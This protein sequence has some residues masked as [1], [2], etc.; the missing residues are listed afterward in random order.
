MSRHFLS[1]ITLIIVLPIVLFSSLS[2]KNVTISGVVNNPEGKP[3]KKVNV[4]IR[5]LKDEI[6]METT[7]NRKGQFKFEDVK[8][9]F[10]FLLA[11]DLG[12]GSKRIKI[13]P[14]KN[15]NSDMDLTF[16]LNGREQDVECYLFSNKPPTNT[17]PILGIKKIKAKSTAESI[18]LSWKDIKQAKL[19]TLYE[20]EVEIYSGE[21]PRFEKEVT[22]GIEYCY[23]VKASSD[24]GLEGEISSQ[25]CISA[26]TQI[27][28]N[29]KI[30][31]YKN[32]FSFHW[33]YVKGALAYNIF[34]DDEK[35]A[36]VNDTSFQD[37]NLE[38]D[39]EYYYKISAVDALNKESEFSIEL[40]A[41]THKLIEAPILSSINS[42]NNITLIWN[43]VD[44]TKFYN[45]YRDG[46]F[47]ASDEGN[48]FIDKVKRGQKYC[49]EISCVDEFDIESDKS[50]KY[51]KKLFLD[52]PKGLIA[53]ADINSMNLSWDTVKDAA[54]YM[55]YEKVSSDEFKYIGESTVSNYKVKSLDFSANIC[56]SITA[57][58]KE[59]DESGY[60]ISACNRVFD[61]PHFTIQSHKLIEPSGNGALDARENGS[62]Q[63]AIFNDGQSPAHNIII[64]VLPVDPDPN[65]VLGAPIILDTL[66]AGRIKFVKIDIKSLLEVK[67]GEYQL[68]LKLSSKD[69]IKLDEQYLLNISTKSM[70]PPKMIVA[71]FAITND[72]NTRYIPKNETVNLTIRVQNV[73][74]GDTE[75]VDV[76]IKENRTFRTPG[77]TGR[78]TLPRFSPGD[79]MDIEL[80]IKTLLD[81]FFINVE[82][83]DYL[84]NIYDHRIDF[85]TMRN[86]RSPMELTIQDLGTE[87]VIYYPDELGEIDVDRHIPLSRKNPSGLAIVF[88]IEDYEDLRYPKLKF[89]SRD[90]EVMRKYFNQAFGL[91]D[92]QLLP[93][94]PWQME[95]GPS[96]EEYRIIFDPYDGD[97]RKRINSAVKYSNMDEINIFLYYR[98]YGEWVNGQPLLIPKNAKFDRHVTK[99]PIEDLIGSLTTLSIL[100]SIKTI[101]LFLDI[102]YINPE[103]S[104][105]SVWDFP[106]LPEKISILSA[107]SNGETSQI[108]QDKKHSFFTYSLL[109]GFAGAAD[110]GDN[111][112]NLGE[113]TD[114]VYRSVPKYIDQ[115]PGFINQN[116]S[117]SGKDLKR[118]ILDLR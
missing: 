64:S 105:G 24:F 34:R 76:N 83:K 49:Y 48:S 90:R 81:Q 103:K 108:Y 46:V 56:Y 33:T 40:K 85:Q 60:S 117:F 87:N 62:I 1:I 79:Y 68:E 52:S 78:V 42:K 75:Y 41:T 54:Y 4:S 23:T 99:Y 67:T 11:K 2:G 15:K 71:D 118:T 14:R 36:T 26:R 73:G 77:F 95:G 94:K 113:I 101:T 102:T 96:E 44:G 97:L 16:E 20:N 74:E 104:S 80:P 3:I 28:R 13:N 39:S 65:L 50:N 63:F 10:Y 21:N 51:C 37:I 93:S 91:S 55:I 30:D 43:E 70:T 69:K 38:F 7:T 106:E 89:A 61:P 66:R 92:F 86:Y 31:I 109:K 12:Y 58:D 107:S 25:V 53:D 19:Y 5:N 100:N 27:P 47:L 82:L 45:V 110:D 17:D 111:V 22:P 57:V 72:F 116:P 9:R 35:I 98:G 6:F 114:Y 88:G 18:S 32:T 84:D 112:I 115:V 29:I 59:E 8:P